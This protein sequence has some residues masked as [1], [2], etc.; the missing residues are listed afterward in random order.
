MRLTSRASVLGDHVRRL[1]ADHVDRRDDE[2]ARDAG[3]DRGID[4]PQ[5]L[6]ADDAEAAVDDRRRVTQSVNGVL[7][8]TVLVDGFVA[9]T[10]TLDRGRDVSRL[11]VTALESIPRKHAAA[12]RAEGRGLLGLLAANAAKIEVVI[13]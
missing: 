1:L 11:L 8:G 13:R 6:R 7:P 10:W 9:A 3:E 12:V 5:A 2:E 4:D